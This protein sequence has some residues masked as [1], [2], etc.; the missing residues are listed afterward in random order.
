LGQ[1]AAVGA[2]DEECHADAVLVGV[3]GCGRADIVDDVD[4]RCR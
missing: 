3:S 4:I 1:F 2:N